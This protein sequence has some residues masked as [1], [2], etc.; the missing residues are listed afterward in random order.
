MSKK[1]PLFST[2]ATASTLIL[3]IVTPPT[4]S[5]QT[6]GNTLPSPVAIAP[7]IPESVDT[8]WPGGTITLDVDGADVE[9]GVWHV[10]ETVP[11]AGATD[12]IIL[13]LP[14][15]LP[16]HHEPSDNLAQISDVRFS[17]A[18][19]PVAWVRDR[20]NP[21]AFHVKLPAGATA[22][23]A[24][25]VNASPLQG[26]EGQILKTHEMLNAEWPALSLYPAGHYTRRIAIRPSLKLPA[27]WSFASA[28]D[29]ATRQGD[30]VTWATTDYD[31]LIDSPVFAG[32][33]YKRLDL[34]QGI[35]L[36]AFADKPENLNFAPEAA[37]AYR[38]LA[39]EAVLNFGARHFD[40]YD[41]LLGLT[42][43]LGSVGLEH[44]RSSENTVLP[45][46]LVDW[47]A[48]D[49][50]RNV[51][52]HEL[53][54]SWDG[55]FRR[56]ADLWTPDYHTPMQDDLLWVYEGQTQFWGL[57]LAARS[58]V[59][60]KD[61]VL[62]AIA[63]YAGGFTDQAGRGW[64]SVADTTNDPVIDARRP[65]AFAS[66][67]RG[68][69]YYTEG[70]L[71][72]LEADQIIRAGTHGQKSLGDFARAFFGL[73]DGDWGELTYTRADVV[74]T[75]NN[76]YPYDWEA[77]LDTRID[78]V[79]QPA[80]LAGIALGGYKLV[81]KDTPNPYD[82]GVMAQY[83]TL[84]LAHALGVTL[85]KDGKVTGALWGSP[86]FNA[87]IVTGAKIVSA[88]GT[89][90]S[91]DAMKAA[92]TA[93]K[94]PAVPLTLVVQRGDRVET[95]VVPYHDGLRWPWLEKAGKGPAG[96]DALLAP[97]RK[98]A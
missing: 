75:L 64:R 9:R 37:P 6:A 26:S 8:A 98:G 2:A 92:I 74:A 16:G 96:L 35:A 25:F 48:L 57:V 81:W 94:A 51:L 97:L 23:T 78:G 59:Q 32:I 58:G 85:D 82:K 72:W 68:E 91:E 79:G 60:S 71:V 66:L 39:E 44:H 21:F 4:A 24:Q 61:M 46:A 56:G 27:G 18:G 87:G 33:N 17:V 7:T 36:D 12:E 20:I 29:G 63:R 28:L 42:D 69:D 31:T 84:D 40:H 11:L 19:Q 30:T 73:R 22:V 65:K 89:A 10:T 53:T 49:W 43:R 1:F 86:A 14:K 47:A 95:I 34:G 50:D 3:A 45:K 70:A 5:A 52:A 90:W 88:N 77:F 38:A 41:L 55:K 80:P 83:H 76:V 54:H 93:A 13:L 67:N 15:W 62:A